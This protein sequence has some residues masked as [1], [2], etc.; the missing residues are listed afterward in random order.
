MTSLYP[1]LVFY[2]CHSGLRR[3][4]SQSYLKILAAVSDQRSAVSFQHLHERGEHAFQLCGSQGQL[5]RVGGLD[6][7][8]GFGKEQMT[9]QFAG[10][11]HCD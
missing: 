8:Q 7:A 9:F 3:N 6:P 1:H 4:A 2:N 5:F 11:C 10:G